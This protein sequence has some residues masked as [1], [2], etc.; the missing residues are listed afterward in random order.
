MYTTKTVDSQT[1]SPWIPLDDNQA[2]FNVS[3]AVAVTGV[4]TYTVQFTLDNIQDPSITPV[5]FDVSSLTSKTSNASTSL[6]SSV[7]AVRLNVT[8]YTSGSATIGVRQGTSWDGIDFATSNEPVTLYQT[9]PL[10][11][12]TFGHSKAD[13]RAGLTPTQWD[14]TVITPTWPA[15]GLTL[16]S[17]RADRYSLPLLYPMAF[18]V[19]TGGIGSQTTAQMLARDANAA[20]ATRFAIQDVID[21]APDVCL[22]RADAVNDFAAST[23]AT[24]T[25]SVIDASYANM[26]AVLNRLAAGVPYLIVSGFMGYNHSGVAA[27]IAARKAALLQLDTRIAEYIAANLSG[28]A[29]F[30]ASVGNTCDS[31]GAFYTGYSDD[32]MHLGGRGSFVHD[33]LEAAALVR[34]FGLPRK[35]PRYVGKNNI[36]NSL[37]SATSNVTEGVTATGITLSSTQATRANAKIEIIDGVPW[38]T[39]ELTPTGVS[40]AS[41]ALAFTFPPSF[42]N[43]GEIYGFEFD[44]FVEGL[45]GGRLPITGVQSINARLYMPKTS[46]GNIIFDAAYG[47]SDPNM[48]ERYGGKAIFPP[49]NFGT[50]SGATLG[51]IQMLVQVAAITDYVPFR[52]GFSHPRAVKQ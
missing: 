34:R 40:A 42:I 33:R 12:A 3:V 41:A 6:R 15:S 31:T 48:T 26:V 27:D 1:T 50:E 2:A 51:S 47:N 30:I 5:A 39:V 24:L 52:F 21:S 4:L 35:G 44:W 49:I 23:A 17:H 32:D 18:L 36:S 28:R 38:Q 25:Q 16:M 14:Q 7:K 46:N 11:V 22:V 9:T 29:E 45:N 10:R 8:S 37:F 43:A 13:V 20:S 19:C